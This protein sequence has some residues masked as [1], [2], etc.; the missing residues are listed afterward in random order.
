MGVY[1]GLRRAEVDLRTRALVC[2]SEWET[3][4]QNRCPASVAVEGVGF[5][6]DMLPPESRERPVKPAGV[7][8]M[9]TILRH[10]RT[11]E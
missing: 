10:L 11:P 2:F 9:H 7:Q 5:I 4:L 8:R 3:Q 1:S 6:W